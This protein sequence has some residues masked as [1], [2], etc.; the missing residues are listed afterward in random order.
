[1]GGRRAEHEPGDS[2][3]G[4]DAVTHGFRSIFRDYA[5]ERTHTPHAV[6][7]A[8]LAHA[9]RNKAEAAYARSDLFEKRRALMESRSEF[10]TGNRA[11][12]RSAET[13]CANAAFRVLRYHS[14]V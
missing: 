3:D 2:Q 8:A 14:R 9:V 5:A 4:L 12:F 7:E 11:S 6:M 10:V 1:M 13:T